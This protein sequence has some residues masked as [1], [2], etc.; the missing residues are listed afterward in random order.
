M[1]LRAAGLSDVSNRGLV[2]SVFVFFSLYMQ[3]TLVWTQM[4]VTSN[5]V[6]HF[7]QKHS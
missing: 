2:A 5:T 7:T 4:S 6:G 3:V 1:R